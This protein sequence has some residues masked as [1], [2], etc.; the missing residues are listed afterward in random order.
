MA[1]TNND[2]Y[3]LINFVIRK[4]S[5][6]Q[7]LTR[8]NFTIL[9]DTN[10][11]DHFEILY[12]SYERTQEISDSLRRFKSTKTGGQ[13]SFTDSKINI[14]TDYAHSGFLYYKKNGT[15]V[16][17]VYIVDDDKFMMRQNSFIEE[18]TSDYPIARF[19]DGYIQYLPTTLDTNNFTFSYLRYPISPVYDYYIDANGVVQYLAE[20]EGHDWEDGETDSSGVI[21]YA[22]SGSLSGYEYTSLTKELDFNEEDKLKVAYRILQAVGVPINEAG[23]YQYAEQLKRES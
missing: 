7:P 23:V 17:P 14:P 18:P 4:D 15:D 2:I 6:G 13:L 9:L 10:G 1:Y 5:K 8:E 3:N 22:S 11:L 12:N 21:H 16:K 20:G 19:V